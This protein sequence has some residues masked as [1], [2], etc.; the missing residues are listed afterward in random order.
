[1][2]DAVIQFTLM[3]ITR[4]YEMN[5]NEFFCY[6]DYIRAR[7]KRKADEIRRFQKR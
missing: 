2:M 6:V 5:A 4:I 1:M 7:E 3:D